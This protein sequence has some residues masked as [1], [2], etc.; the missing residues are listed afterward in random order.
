MA[1]H[2]LRLVIWSVQRITLQALIDRVTQ[3]RREGKFFGNL[4]KP[5]LAKQAAA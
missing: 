5:H 3:K 1:E 2:P 4:L